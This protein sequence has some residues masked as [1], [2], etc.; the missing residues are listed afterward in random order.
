MHTS[1]LKRKAQI[2]DDAL[3]LAIAVNDLGAAW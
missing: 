1:A 2:S 3:T